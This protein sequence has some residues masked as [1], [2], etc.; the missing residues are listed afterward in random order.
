MVTGPDSDLSHHN[1]PF[2][3]PAWSAWPAAIATRN[4]SRESR[5]QTTWFGGRVSWTGNNSLSTR[6][7]TLQGDIFRR[8]DRQVRM[9]S[10]D[11]EAP[12]DG[13]VKQISITI[14]T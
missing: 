4:E 10:V 11:R 7:E 1:K 6:D 2:R 9:N 3:I 5:V 8:G 13:Y 14:D 12:I